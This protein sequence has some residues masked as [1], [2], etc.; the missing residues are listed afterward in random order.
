MYKCGHCVAGA[1]IPLFLMCESSY[2]GFRRNEDMK[3]IEVLTI[4]KEKVAFLSGE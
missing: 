3:A 4:L 1:F 2:S